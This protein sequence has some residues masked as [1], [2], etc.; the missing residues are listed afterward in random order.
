MHDEMVHVGHN[1]CIHC[2]HALKRWRAGGGG[3]LKEYKRSIREG[4]GHE[5]LRVI[6]RIS[7]IG[8]EDGGDFPLVVR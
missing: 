7:G 4:G 3:G 5:A 6:S 1:G 2:V 8:N